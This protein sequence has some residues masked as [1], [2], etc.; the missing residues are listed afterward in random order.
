MNPT[1]PEVTSARLESSILTGSLY[2]VAEIR[3]AEARYAEANPGQSLMQRAGEAVAAAVRRYA[4][5]RVLILAG[6]G[7]NGGD[8]WVAARLLQR[9][10]VDVTVCAF[11]DQSRGEAAAQLARKAYLKAIGKILAIGSKPNNHAD[12][13]GFDLI[14]DGLFGS[15]FTPRPG[16][17]AIV[18]AMRAANAARSTGTCRILAIDIPSG[19]AADTGLASAETIA[20]DETITF[21]GAKPGL[22]TADGCDT[23][24]RVTLDGLG[25]ALPPSTTA[26]LNATVVM[27]MLPAR[28]RNSHKG[29]YGTVGV[30]GGARGMVGAAV[31]A[32]RAALMFGAGRVM[33]A[34][35]GAANIG[36]DPQHPEIMIGSAALLPTLS[37]ITS[38]A[39]GMGMGMTAGSA[40]C[41]A[42]VLNTKKPTVLDADALTL[43]AAKP[44]LRARFGV[45]APSAKLTRTQIAIVM[46]PHPGEA[47]RLLGMTTVAIQSDRLHA[48]RE[49]A[50]QYGV[51]IVLK[52]AGTLVAHPDGRLAINTT[53]NPGMASGGMGDVLAG[54]IAALLAQGLAPWEAACLGVWVHGAAADASVARGDGP[55]GFIASDVLV[56]ARRVLNALRAPSPAP[57]S[58]PSPDPGSH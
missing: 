4:P 6:P 33:L 14:V 40:R 5:K 37:T 27:A 18:A 13:G 26:L 57:A 11:G 1:T 23:S 25:V 55:I 54:M 46:T 2:T 52:G 39:I 28:K 15:G 41:L 45:F 43:I 44:K 21:I 53:G 50:R 49:L 32:A 31:L 56:E 12:F 48:A 10:K 9:A 30:I 19:L 7:N 8:A 17:E 38:Y 22:Y 51:V 58:P 36:F 34:A 24:G 16:N 20:A 29:N 3:A 35:E 47:A 42:Q